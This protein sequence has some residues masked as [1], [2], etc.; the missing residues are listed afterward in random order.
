MATRRETAQRKQQLEKWI[1]EWARQPEALAGGTLSSN[2]DL[3]ERY[4]LSTF[5]VFSV[6]QALV[7]DGVL[8]S[9]RG[10]GVFSAGWRTD[11]GY[12]AVVTNPTHSLRD[13]QLFEGFRMKLAEF[14]LPSIL[15]SGSDVERW[16]ASG[17]APSVTGVLSLDYSPAGEGSE[18]IDAPTVGFYGLGRSTWDTV[19]FDDQVGGYWATKHLISCGHKRIAFLG[20]H[21]PDGKISL[22]WSK[23]RCS[24]WSSAMSDAGFSVAG[25]HVRNT[26]EPD[27]D[28]LAVGRNAVDRV[29][30][31][32]D[33]SAVIAA[34]SLVAAGFLAGLE[35]R[36]VPRI[37]WPAIVCFQDSD[38]PELVNMS[39]VYLD[40]CAL[41]RAAAE[42]LL[43]L[44]VNREASAEVFRV[45]PQLVPSL[46]SRSG[47]AQSVYSSRENSFRWLH[48]LIEPEGVVK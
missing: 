36:H 7:S 37:A 31:L 44:Q 38:T 28:G 48:D 24:G 16:V 10:V 33:C 8:V 27:S 13:T 47:W 12:F 32:S 17:S 2:R 18:L 41:G 43:R 4:G 26:L 34:N 6:I 22:D 46:T 9:E 11:V 14:G 1:R 21:Y 42:V 45:T 23:D 5:S 20:Y 29:L 15:V 39:S 19:A 30:D 35:S 3:A 25:L 40:Y